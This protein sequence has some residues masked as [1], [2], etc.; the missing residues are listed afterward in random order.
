LRGKHEDRVDIF[1]KNERSKTLKTASVKGLS[2]LFSA[3]RN[4]LIYTTNLDSISQSAEDRRV[5]LLPTAAESD[6]AYTKFHGIHSTVAKRPGGDYIHPGV[7]AAII[8]GLNPWFIDDE[9]SCRP[10]LIP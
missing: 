7:L 6:Q 3:M 1:S 5:T 4:L 2:G 10:I 8:L 9:Y